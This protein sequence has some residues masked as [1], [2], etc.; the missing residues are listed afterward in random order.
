MDGQ[1]LSATVETIGVVTSGFAATLGVGLITGSYKAILRTQ[2]DKRNNDEPH[3][4]IDGELRHSKWS[5][6][7]DTV[8][9]CGRVDNLDILYGFALIS[10]SPKIILGIKDLPGMC[11]KS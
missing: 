10:L 9:S 2:L 5:W 1:V 11:P 6:V 3:T 7:G 8:D 4:V